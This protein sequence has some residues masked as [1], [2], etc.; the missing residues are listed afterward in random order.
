[1]KQTSPR[2][3]GRV[4]VSCDKNRLRLSLPRQLFDGKQKRISLNL[5]CTPAN[6]KIAEEKAR[7][8]QE[9]IEA[10]RFD[11]SLERYKIKANPE[12]P[13]GKP[14]PKHATLSGLYQR[15]IDTKKSTAS[16]GTW[17]NGYLVMSRHIERSPFRDTEITAILGQEVYDWAIEKLTPDTTSRLMTQLNA[18][19]E[20]AIDLRLVPGPSPFNR[21]SRKAKKHIKKSK[22]GD[23]KPFTTDERDAIIRAFAESQYSSYLHNYVRFCFFTGCRPSE[24]IALR[25][26]DIA[27]DLTQL[28][29]QSAIVT[30]K[31][32]RKRCDKLKTEPSREFP[33]NNQVQAILRDVRERSVYRRTSDSKIVFPSKRGVILDIGNF[34]HRHWKPILADLGIEYRKPYQMRHTFITLCLEAGVEVK[35]VAHLVGNSPETI[36]KFYAGRKQGLSVPEL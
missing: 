28:T 26:S 33:C 5:T 11:Y 10:G 29:F 9:E 4:G 24:A 3:K 13:P 27:P 32:G 25:W 34:Q 16:P 6:R 30:G 36:Y 31:G 7:F 35:D 8:I 14:T 19:Y 21:L 1:M 23:I 18:C 15:Y 12:P 2:R 17:K 22:K 20:W